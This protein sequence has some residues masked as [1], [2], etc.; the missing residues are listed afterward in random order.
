MAGGI[1]YAAYM[2]EKPIGQDIGI[3][4]FRKTSIFLDVSVD[5]NP[6]GSAEYWTDHD[7]KF[8]LWA[9]T[10]SGEKNIYAA[11]GDTN[12]DGYYVF[13]IPLATYTHCLFVRANPGVTTNL[14]LSNNTWVWNQTD[15]LSLYSTEQN[16]ASNHYYDYN[17]YQIQSWHGGTN[18]HSGG[19]WQ[20]K[21]S[22]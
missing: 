8:F 18:D 20:A 21:Y 14:V 9:W 3:D 7:A 15:D 1:T 17:L 4:G 10:G 5:L 2:Q 12:Q 6:G 16:T 19:S 11:L 22:G 13:Q